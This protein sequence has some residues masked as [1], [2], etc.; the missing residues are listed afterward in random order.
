MRLL[1]I[2][3]RLAKLIFARR[4]AYF[5]K[6]LDTRG[7]QLSELRKMLRFPIIP[8]NKVQ[9]KFTISG[10]IPFKKFVTFGKVCLAGKFV[11]H[12]SNAMV[13]QSKNNSQ[14]ET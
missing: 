12:P 1:T 2:S 7:L 9:N 8:S 10:A 13:L 6:T 11:I 14:N 5:T 3:K 4:F